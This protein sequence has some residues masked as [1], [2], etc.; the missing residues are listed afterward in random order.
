MN[1]TKSILKITGVVIS[2]LILGGTFFLRAEQNLET[3]IASDYSTNFFTLWGA[4]NMVTRGEN[5]YDVTRYLANHDRYGIEW[6]PNQL[7]PYPLPL[8]LLMA[9]LGM[10][11]LPVAFMVWQFITQIIIAAIIYILLNRWGT[12]AHQRLF[13]PLTIFLLFFGPVV[14]GMKTGSVSALALLFV[15]MSILLFEKEKPFAAGMVL[16][17]CTPGMPDRSSIQFA[18]VCSY[19]RINSS[20]F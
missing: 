10:L 5:P 3:T 14:L 16:A 11:S 2:L 1:Q 12:S 13:V 8:A 7:F 18:T 17:T 15:F 4:G 9:P 6:R 20:S 19:P